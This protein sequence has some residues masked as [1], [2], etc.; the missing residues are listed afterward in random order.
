[1]K[2]MADWYW[3]GYDAGDLDCKVEVGA[4]FLYGVEG[5]VLKNEKK[6]FQIIEEAYQAG[7]QAAIWR[8]GQCYL[9]GL[10]TS[11]NPYK[12]FALFKEGSSVSP[13]SKFLLGQMYLQGLGTEKDERTGLVL[14]E[15]AASVSDN[16]V[17]KFAL[18][19]AYA[20]GV[21]GV[22]IDNAKAVKLFEQSALEGYD[23][24]MLELGRAYYFG[25]M[26]K[27]DKLAAKKWL[28]MAKE[29][30]VKE[31][32]ELLEKIDNQ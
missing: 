19:K 28:Q 32:G 15:E 1:M 23:K 25:T 10:G 3:R 18:G 6:G 27:E 26:V 21:W 16:P 2:Q 12:A 14:V 22:G 7:N 8:L 4:M 17:P 30:G 5:S 29:K 13:T 31:A 20:T 24:A 9:E 11:K